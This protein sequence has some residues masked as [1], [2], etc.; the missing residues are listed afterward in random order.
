MVIVWVNTFLTGNT[1]SVSKIIFSYIQIEEHE[2][3]DAFFQFILPSPN[4]YIA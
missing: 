3:I 4:L 2:S 1:D